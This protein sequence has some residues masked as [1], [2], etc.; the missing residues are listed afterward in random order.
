MALQEKGAVLF[1]AIDGYV[2]M[3]NVLMKN[4]SLIRKWAGYLL[5]SCG[6]ENM[7]RGTRK[8]GERKRRG[9]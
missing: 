9:M 1:S 6:G 3:K 2:Y 4:L 5:L 7:K 8:K